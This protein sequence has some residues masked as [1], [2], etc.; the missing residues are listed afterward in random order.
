MKKKTSH[1][2]LH[3]TMPRSRAK[4]GYDTNIPENLVEL[5]NKFHVD[6]HRI[7]LNMRPDE[8]LEIWYDVNKK[9]LAHETRNKVLDL[10]GMP[11]QRFYIRELWEGL[12]RRKTRKKVFHVVD[13]QLQLP[14]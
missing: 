12:M 3:H 6:W 7:F 1:G 5:D 11:K 4:E 13:E 10:L 2:S 8:Q 14:I 9:I